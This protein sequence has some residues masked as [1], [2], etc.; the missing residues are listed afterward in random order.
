MLKHL[1]YSVKFP[2]TGR[3]LSADVD[4]QKG[5]TAITGP[6]ESGKSMIVE[7]IRY[8]FFGTAA[9]RGSSDSYD[10]LNAELSWDNYKVKRNGKKAEF[11]RD[12]EIVA[13]GVKPVNA[14]I[15]ETLGFG[16]DV[17]D[18]SCVANQG[19]VEKLTSMRPADRKRMVDS[20]IG[21]S[22][23]ED[24]AK[25]AND[26][27]KAQK[28]LADEIE[29]MLGPE[30][31]EPV[32]PSDYQS[33][34]D[35]KE[36]LDE[37]RLKQAE[38]QE[39]RGWLQHTRTEPQMPKAPTSTPTEV[40]KFESER[41]A[42]RSYLE[43]EKANLPEPS[44][45]SDEYLDKVESKIE[46]YQKAQELEKWFEQN[47][48][49]DYFHEDLD[50]ME[51]E[52]KLI[53]LFD[54]YH[55]LQTTLDNLPNDQKCPSCGHE[56]HGNVSY[57][58]HLK[59]KLSE[60]DAPSERPAL[61]RFSKESIP[62]ARR[63][64]DEWEIPDR[65]KDVPESPP[66]P[67]MTMEEIKRYR[68][69]NRKGA[70]RLEIDK[71]L[72]SLPKTDRDWSTIYQQCL[73]YEA[74]M[75]SYK[76]EAQ[77]YREWQA[78]KSLKEAQLHKLENDT[79]DFDLIS[80]T[81]HRMIQYENDLARYN[82]A[83]S[84]YRDRYAK[85]TEHRTRSEEWY[86]AKQAMT[87]LRAM[88]KQHL[89]PSLNKVSSVL[90]TKMTGGQRQ[91]IQVDEEFNIL[92]DGQPVETLSGSGK[93]VVNL[94]LRIGLGQVLT[95]NVMSLFMGDEIDASMD[96]ERADKTTQTLKALV[97]HLSQVILVTHKSPEADHVINLGG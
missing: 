92:V 4:F 91:T 76:Q 57:A 86:K 88:I 41:Q 77:A 67:E 96:S 81:Y 34:S 89:M 15:V 66:E 49:P 9:L 64:L 54:K 3:S 46:M 24:L 19:D 69:A 6:N 2:A 39:I 70:R 55:E 44:P 40:V 45:Y 95:K 68:I 23:I 53:E 73:R 84:N 30:P 8:C 31:E 5:V 52:W 36:T 82:E 72:A 13:K 22:I 27:G 93:A 28:R 48:V 94:A 32:A 80:E 85:V 56:F 65:L 87:T 29:E 35:L 20:V 7:M 17:F 42:Q 47:P 16:L 11:L 58:E 51:E 26:E 10:S 83:I 25:W 97:D 90:L 37:Y 50:R 75:E 14:K 60:I 59:A 33:S 38:A 43:A 1:S 21:V 79:K 78:E 12:G 71:E 74:A 62:Y 18:T 61:P 63:Y